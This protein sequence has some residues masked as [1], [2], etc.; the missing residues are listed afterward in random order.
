MVND[1]VAAVIELD[2][3]KKV[4][5]I[6]SLVVDPKYFRQGIGRK[7]VQ[8]VLDKY[9]VELITV[10]TGVDN[11]PAISLYKSFGFKEIKQW[12]TD[13]G[14]RKIRFEILKK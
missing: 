4:V 2:A 14:V 7:L 12:D 3:N 8:Y 1:N 5:H 10:E 13:H 11:L 6:Q 9:E